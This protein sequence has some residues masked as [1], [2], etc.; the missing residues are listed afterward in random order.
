MES[1][2]ELIGNHLQEKFG[3]DLIGHELLYDIPTFTVKKE[4]ILDVLEDLY[5][6]LGFQFL[7][8]LCGVHFPNNPN[9]ELGVVYHLHNLVTNER[10]RIKIYTSDKNPS[11]LSVTPIF[12]TA[13]WLERETYDFYGIDFKGHPNLTK[14]LNMDDQPYFPMRKEFPLEDGTREDKLDKMFGR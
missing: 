3:A 2:T 1:N 11:V 9:Q 7:T 4:R 13:N 6:Q 14:I 8:D 10:I 12:S 5:T